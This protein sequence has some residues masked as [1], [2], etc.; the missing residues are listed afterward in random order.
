VKTNIGGWQVDKSGLFYETNYSIGDIFTAQFYLTSSYTPSEITTELTDDSN[1]GDVDANG[2]PNGNTNISHFYRTPDPFGSGSVFEVAG[3]RLTTNVINGYDGSGTLGVFTLEGPELYAA[4]SSVDI[5]SYVTSSF[6]I[7]SGGSP[8]SDIVWQA[9][10]D[11]IHSYEEDT[12]NAGDIAESWAVTTNYPNLDTENFFGPQIYAPHSNAYILAEGVTIPA[13]GAV[14]AYVSSSL[15]IKLF[16]PAPLANDGDSMITTEISNPFGGDVRLD[17]ATKLTLYTIHQT[18]ELIFLNGFGNVTAGSVATS[19]ITGDAIRLSASGSVGGGNKPFVS[20]GQATASYDSRGIF[21]GFP[22]GSEIPQFS[23]RSPGGNFLRYNGDSVQYSG[24]FTGGTIGQSSIVGGSISVPGIN[25]DAKFSVDAAGNVSASNANIGGIINA[26]SGRIGDWIIDA[27]TKALRD[28]NSEIIFEPNI[29]ELQ[30]FADGVKKVI[31]GPQGTLTD[32]LN[33]ATSSVEFAS[34]AAAKPS[35]TITKSNSFSTSNNILSE[36]SSGNT[37]TIGVIDIVSVG[38]VTLTLDTPNMTLIPPSRMISQTVSYP[39]YSPTSDGQKHGSTIG[40]VPI[41]Q[42]GYL[43]LE[44]VS[45][46]NDVVIGRTLI[47]QTSYAQSGRAGKGNYYD[48][49]YIDTGG[50]GGGVGSDSFSVVADTK[51]TLSDGSEILAKDVKAGQRIL[52]WN[53]NEKIDTHTGV[54]GFSEFTIDDVKT[55]TTTEIYKITVGDKFV[56]VSDSHGFWKENNTELPANELI[57]GVSEIYVKDGDTISLQLVDK[58]EILEGAKVYTFSVP[59][60]YNYI[61]ND[62]IS[63]NTITAYWDYVAL[64]TPGGFSATNGTYTGL[65]AQS[66]SIPVTKVASEAKLRYSVRVSTSAG[67]QQNTNSSGTNTNIYTN[68]VVTYNNNNNSSTYSEGFL[69][70]TGTLD[71]IIDYSPPTNFV[72]IKAGGIQVV[73]SAN[74][75][76]I[77]KRKNTTDTDD[78]DLFRLTGGTAFFNNGYNGGGTTSGGSAPSNADPAIVADGNILPETHDL[79]TLGSSNFNWDVV[80]ATTST[81]Q[82]SDETKKKDMVTSDLGLNF[83]NALNPIS[84]RFTSGS[85]T[86]YGLGAQSVETVLESFEKDSVG[87]AGLITGSAYGLRYQEF[88]SPMIKAIQELTNKVTQLE[89]QISGS[90]T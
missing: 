31:I 25:G 90:I 71:T 72:E 79:W 1:I 19:D 56:E 46:S 36:Y 64:L 39:S 18:G 8:G 49:T 33:A 52:A 78:P 51:I 89:A 63:H 68:G 9:G 13:T 59:G 74:Q 47:G 28:D 48:G 75:S 55:R 73:S 20:I 61:S 40:P 69:N 62:I 53:W 41:K 70:L 27:D 11:T 21:L 37:S 83:I 85:R 4:S 87:F 17:T 14:A 54:D 50:S 66:I 76:V 6:D 86:H 23:M 16:N 30:M 67:F 29:P 2:S 65:S 45:G 82:T 80:Y 57:A 43:Y 7:T 22:S 32:T 38:D 12:Y 10:S 34:A 42:V 84:Y 24:D 77:I 35:T 26:N 15:A 60:V 44:V 81:I 3:A 58:V 88:I 5:K